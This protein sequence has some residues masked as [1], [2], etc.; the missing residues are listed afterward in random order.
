[1]NLFIVTSGVYLGVAALGAFRLVQS[2]F[3]ILNLV[4]QTFENYVLPQ[5]SVKYNESATKAKYE[6]LFFDFS[7]KNTGVLT[8]RAQMTEEFIIYFMNQSDTFFSKR[9]FHFGVLK[10]VF[11]GF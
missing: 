2:L 3:G 1:M 11:Y 10:K 8:F 5:A 9:V 7:I 4:L 6:K